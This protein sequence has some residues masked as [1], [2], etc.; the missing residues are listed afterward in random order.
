[1]KLEVFSFL[2]PDAG[3]VENIDVSDEVFDFPY[4]EDLVYE[5]IRNELAN[6][7]QGTASTKTRGEVRG[8]GRKP[9]PQ[10]GLGR[11]RHGSIRSPIWRGGGVAFGP[12]PRDYSY[13][14]PRKKKRM[15]YRVLISDKVRTGNLKVVDNWNLDTHKTKS[16]YLNLKKFLSFAFGNDEFSRLVIVY[17]DD[18]NRNLKLASRNVPKLILLNSARLIGKEIFYADRVLMDKDSALYVNE[19]L[20]KL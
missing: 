6:V 20:T 8:G 10:K 4:K 14:I 15:A 16:F 5:I 2:N 18:S 3:A 11:A 9:W 19:W 13:S 1:M 17:S 12:K 7:R